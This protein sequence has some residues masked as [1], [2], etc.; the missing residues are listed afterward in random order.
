MGSQYRNWV[1]DIFQGLSAVLIGGVAMYTAHYFWFERFIDQMDEIP[2]GDDAFYNV[3][4]PIFLS[5]P[6][7]IGALVVGLMS[8]F[9]KTRPWQSIGIR[10]LTG[11]ILS[12]GFLVINR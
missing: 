10:L 8:G 9:G 12:L 4:S 7:I 5:L 6:F 3:I 11:P 2:R 1:A